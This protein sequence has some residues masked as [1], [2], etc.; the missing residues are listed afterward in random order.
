MENPLDPLVVLKDRFGKI[1]GVTSARIGLES[2]IAPEDYPIIRLVPSRI[3]AGDA[4]R[5]KIDLLIYF[6]APVLAAEFDNAD[7][8]RVYAALF[9][10]EAAI[11]AQLSPGG[12][13]W[14]AKYVETITDEDRLE[15]YKLMAVRCT[16]EG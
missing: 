1:P 9:D 14:R 15:A 8:E 13:D 4:G 5:R 7:M 10:M 6:G 2:A 12:E 11:I 3:S 16:V